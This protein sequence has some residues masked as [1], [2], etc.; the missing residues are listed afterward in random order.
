MAAR[1]LL[2]ENEGVDPTSPTAAFEATRPRLFGLAYGMRETP[3][4][5]DRERAALEWTEALTRLSETHPSEDLQ[6][7]VATYFDE[8]EIV[9]LTFAVVVINSWNRLVVLLHPPVGTYQ[10]RIAASTP[11]EVG[12]QTS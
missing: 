5:T 6:A 12:A 9:A 10:S 8:D 3:F 1:L 7:R 2:V 4:F 11:E